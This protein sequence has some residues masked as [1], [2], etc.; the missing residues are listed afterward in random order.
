M[1]TKLVL[2]GTPSYAFADLGHI[3]M[4]MEPDNTDTE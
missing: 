3:P 1:F 4:V 2:K